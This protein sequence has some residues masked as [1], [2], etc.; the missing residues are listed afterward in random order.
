MSRQIMIPT[1]HLPAA[2]TLFSLTAR[3][4]PSTQKR[5]AKGRALCIFG[6]WIPITTGHLGIMFTSNTRALSL[7]T[8]T[9]IV[10]MTVLCAGLMQL[11]SVLVTPTT[12]A[13]PLLRSV[14]L[15]NIGYNYQRSRCL[16]AVISALTILQP[17]LRNAHLSIRATVTRSTIGGRNG[18]LRKADIEKA[19]PVS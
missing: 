19:A 15:R 1:H 4:P 5:P 2:K 3:R 14:V 6:L 18:P 12:T 17:V 8:S 9:R 7:S 13:D 11:A 10:K 16:C